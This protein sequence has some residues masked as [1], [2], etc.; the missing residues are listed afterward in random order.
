MLDSQQKLTSS[1]FHPFLATSE[2]PSLGPEVRANRKEITELESNLSTAFREAKL[3]ADK[4]EAV[5]ALVL[6]WNDYLDE[7]HSLSQDIP[8]ADGSFI[9]G[10]VHRREPDYGNAKYWFHRV[11]KHAAFP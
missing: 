10:I 11:G 7:A 3:S 5:R 8:S 4:Q 9:H 6:L 1:L 2:L